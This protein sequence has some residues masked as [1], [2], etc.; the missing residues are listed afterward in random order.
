MTRVALG[1]LILFSQGGGCIRLQEGK[2]EW[3]ET[4]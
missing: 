4:Q 3:R 2:P 1:K